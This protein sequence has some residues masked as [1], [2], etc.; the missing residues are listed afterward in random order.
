M[1]WDRRQ[2][3]DFVRRAKEPYG[4]CWSLLGGDYQDRIIDA[5]V[6]SAVRAQTFACVPANEIAELRTAMR[7]EAG[8]EEG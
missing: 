7:H 6:L 3:R 4:S 1:I 8:L 5:A 2:I